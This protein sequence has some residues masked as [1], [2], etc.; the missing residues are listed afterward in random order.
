[1]N[2]KLSYTMIVGALFALSGCGGSGG[3]FGGDSSVRSAT[4]VVKP[5]IKSTNPKGTNQNTGK[6]TNGNNTS[7]TTQNTKP[8]NTNHFAF[9]VPVA[10]KKS[11][12]T[13]HVTRPSAQVEAEIQKVLDGTNRLRAEK[14]LKPLKLDPNLTAYAQ[15]RASEIANVWAHTRM[16]GGSIGNFGEN[17]AAGNSTGEATVEQWRNSKGHYANMVSPAYE[18]I[19]IGM[20]YAPNTQYGYYWVQIFNADIYNGKNFKAP[21]EFASTAQNANQKP[22][23]QLTIDGKTIPLA[24]N[25]TGEWQALTKD[26]QGWVNGYQHTRFGVATPTGTNASQLYYQ[27]HRTDDTAIPKSGTANYKGT[28]LVVKGT[29]VNTDVKSE[30]TADFG[31]RKLTGKLTQNNAKLYDITADINGGAFASARGASVQTQGAFF[32]NKAEEMAGVFKDTKSDA[33]GVFGAKKQ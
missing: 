25:K 29:A 18:T 4:P 13:S 20:V 17:N 1:M 15:V 24:L 22:L 27:G 32:G 26:A 28:A 3:S 10:D 19:G 5:T 11:W 9:N 23:E 6:N 7:N 31:K 8:A 30:F 2:V 33:K 16:D 14:G 21:Y 12:D